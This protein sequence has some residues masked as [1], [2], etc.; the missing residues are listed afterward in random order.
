MSSASLVEGLGVERIRFPQAM[1]WEP[2][3]Y[4][5]HVMAVVPEELDKQARV[6]GVVLE[7]DYKP[8]GLRWSGRP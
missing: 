1:G 7:E 8:R 2:R 3:T 6:L 5:M 4:G